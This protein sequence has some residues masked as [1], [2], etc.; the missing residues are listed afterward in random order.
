MESTELEHLLA[1]LD[2][3]LEV[4]S[5]NHGLLI[6]GYLLQG[7]K[8]TV[9]IIAGNLL[10]ELSVDD[11]LEVIDVEERDSDISSLAVPVRVTAKRGARLLDC[12]PADEYRPLLERP[13][14]PFAYMVRKNYPPMQD[15]PRF[16][17]R[18]QA[19]RLKHGL[20]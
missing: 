11:I 16:R 2:S 17:E 1:K 14:E 5:Q 7:S 8:E 15:A 6:D 19:Y 9:R 20:E 3:G 18:E 10:L 4:H 13:V 12:T